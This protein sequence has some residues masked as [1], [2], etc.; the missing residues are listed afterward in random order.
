MSTKKVSSLIVPKSFTLEK[1]GIT[2][3]AITMFMAC[4]RKFLFYINRLDAPKS[5]SSAMAFGSLFHAMLD[6]LYV[7]GAV[8]SGEMVNAWFDAETSEYRKNNPLITEQEVEDELAVAMPLFL[9]YLERYGSIDARKKFFSVEKTYAANY[10]G[11]TL[12]MKPDGFFT[13]ENGGAWLME[14]KTKSRIDEE[15]LTQSLGMNFQVLYYITPAK[16]YLNLKNSLVGCLYNIVRK[17]GLRRGKNESLAEFSARIKADI[18]L[19]PEWYFIRQEIAFTPADLKRH[20]M[21]LSA[22]LSDIDSALHDKRRMYR[23]TNACLQP[24]PC[25]FLANCSGDTC[26]GLVKRKTVYRELSE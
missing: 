3:S 4:R 10:M 14:H 25:Q 2:Q 13:A 8:P 17:P 24:Y 22:I 21:E 20:E 6:K 9:G 18:A 11:V 16:K 5:A 19:R 23:N 1:T 26:E 12:R 15:G 7:Y